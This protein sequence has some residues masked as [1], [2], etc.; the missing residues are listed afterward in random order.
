MTGP[1][2]GSAPVENAWQLGETVKDWARGLGMGTPERSPQPR[3]LPA[4]SGELDPRQVLGLLQAWDTAMA[5]DAS[6]RA[7]RAAAAAGRERLPQ[8]QAQLRPSLQLT[9]NWGWNRLDRE[10]E[11]F[12]GNPVSTL[13]RY[14]SR[15]ETLTLRQPLFRQQQQAAVRQAAHLVEDAEALLQRAG[16][17][18]GIRVTGA[19]LEALLSRDQLM[20]VQTQQRFLTRQLDAAQRSLLRGTGTRTDVDE[21]RARLDLN[22]ASELEARQQV[23]SAGRQLQT[24]LDRPLPELALL[25]ASRLEAVLP[26]PGELDDWV[27]AALDASPELRSLRAQR[28][29]AREELAKARAGHLPTLDLVGQL[30]RSRSENVTAPQS[31]YTN[32]SVALQLNLPLYAGGYV[33][34][35]ERQVQ[36]EYERLGEV[37]EA[38]RRDLGVRVH[39]EHRGVTEGLARAQA[40]AVALNS[41]EVA[42]DS[43]RKS[44]AAGVRTTVDILDAE[45]QRMQV[46]RDLAQARYMALMSTVRLHALAGRV[47]RALMERLAGA[48]Q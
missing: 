38:T 47:D 8:A 14:P 40:L 20:L 7:A 31:A 15:N 48:F 3:V 41:A 26:H 11:D 19:F 9:G 25:D 33:Q 4:A 45:Q 18:L 17:D 6:L 32:A 16:Q 44:Y 21:T 34:S 2:P 37:L 36:A 22:R 43:A 10:S 13:D 46:V 28:E 23:A 12:F 27:T 1:Q 42:L 39:R 35:L 30:Q 29:A 5:N 24:L